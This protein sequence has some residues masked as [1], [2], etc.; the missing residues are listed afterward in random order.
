MRTLEQVDRDIEIA[1]A[2]LHELMRM[3]QPISII[4]EELIELHDERAEI[5]KT[6]ENKRAY[7]IVLDNTFTRFRCNACKS[8]SDTRWD[9]CP[10][11]GAKMDEEIAK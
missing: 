5:L 11:C 2:D 10:H 1:R 3:R 4:G 9:Y 6:L 7:W 8:D